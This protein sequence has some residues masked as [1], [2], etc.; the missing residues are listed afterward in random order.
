MNK[1]I[2]NWVKEDEE[3]LEPYEWHE[4]DD[5]EI[6]SSLTTYHVDKDTLHDFIYGC[7]NIFDKQY[8]NKIFAV[9]NEISCVVVEIDEL[10]KLI[11][12]SVLPFNKRTEIK[13]QIIKQPITSIN[14]YMYDEG[15]VKEYGLTR[16]ERLKKQFIEEKLDLIYLNDCAAFNELCKQ[17]SINDKKCINMYLKLKSKIEHGYSFIHEVL[18]NELVKSKYDQAK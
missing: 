18:Y 8:Y 16:N 1:I 9:G 11:Y 7:L 15:L 4:Y 6:I 13:N 12:R 14:Y 17:L 3:L 2:V 10:G 5:I